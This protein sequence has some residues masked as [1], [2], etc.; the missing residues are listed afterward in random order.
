MAR[1]RPDLKLILAC[2]ANY[3]IEEGPEDQLYGQDD[4]FF[5]SSIDPAHVTVKYEDNEWE[6]E[7]EGV[8]LQVRSGR[9]TSRHTIDIKASLKECSQPSEEGRYSR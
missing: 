1:D 2:Q 7:S 5:S 8:K 4:V 6:Y 3:E 9:S